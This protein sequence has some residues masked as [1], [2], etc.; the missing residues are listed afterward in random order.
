[1]I[2]AREQKPRTRRRAPSHLMGCDHAYS[3]WQRKKRTFRQ[4]LPVE[5]ATR[6]WVNGVEKGN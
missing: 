5:H 2:R 1:M 6:P 3:T 4:R